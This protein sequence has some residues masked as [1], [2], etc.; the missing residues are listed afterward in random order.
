MLGHKFLNFYFNF[1]IITLTQVIED[2]LQEY[3][4]AI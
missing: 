4:Q 1:R 3:F 2:D